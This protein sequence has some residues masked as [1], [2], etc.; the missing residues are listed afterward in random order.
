[1]KTRNVIIILSLATVL[2]GCVHDASVGTMSN[3][4]VQY[5]GHSLN[6]RTLNG[7]ELNGRSLNGINLKNSIN[8]ALALKDLA[9]RPLAKKN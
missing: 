4:R 8:Q 2:G 6:G 1:M 7:H 5:N 3:N 9:S